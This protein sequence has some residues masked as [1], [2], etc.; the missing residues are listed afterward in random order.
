MK[1]TTAGRSRG[2][3][4]G[5]GSED[6]GSLSRFCAS[7]LDRASSWVSEA[8][9]TPRDPGRGL[10]GQGEEGPPSHPQRQ[11]GALLTGLWQALPT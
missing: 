11:H 2:L 1:C 4:P 7:H 6:P 3:T 8:A 9:K 10:A 5:T